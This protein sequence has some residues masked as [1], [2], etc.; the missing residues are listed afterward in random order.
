[1]EDTAGSKEDPEA[2]EAEVFY[3][4]LPACCPVTVGLL[5]QGVTKVV[6]LSWV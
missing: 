1:M 4:K 5:L 6:D 2:P 3:F